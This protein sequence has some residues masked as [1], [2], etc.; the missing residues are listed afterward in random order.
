MDSHHRQRPVSADSA[1]ALTLTV[2][3]WCAP[4]LSA[5]KRRLAWAHFSKVLAIDSPLHCR[6][7]E[8]P[9]RRSL[10][11]SSA[12]SSRSDRSKQASLLRWLQRGKSVSLVK[13]LVLFRLNS[14]LAP[15]YH[16]TSPEWVNRARDHGPRKGYAPGL[17]S[18][19]GGFD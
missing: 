12:N 8:R 10:F 14:L 17:K 9:A 13:V 5:L 11:R 1:T 16:A 2:G 7:N 4:A 15:L 6:K 3:I 18:S 19:L